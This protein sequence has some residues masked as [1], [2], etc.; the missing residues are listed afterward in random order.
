MGTIYHGG[1]KYKLMVASPQKD[2]HVSVKVSR[3]DQQVPVVVL[4]APS[5]SW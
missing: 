5:A 4:L 3:P 1:L 2:L